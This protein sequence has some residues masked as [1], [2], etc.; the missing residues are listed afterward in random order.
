MERPGKGTPDYPFLLQVALGQSI[1]PWQQING[2]T[3]AHA[4]VRR[5]VGDLCAEDLTF[6]PL[7]SIDVAMIGTEE[8]E[9]WVSA[10]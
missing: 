9:N 2:R 4:S 7:R 1:L 10:P 8:K 5:D 3:G 6:I